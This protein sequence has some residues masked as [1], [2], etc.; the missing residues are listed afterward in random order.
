VAWPTMRVLKEL[1]SGWEDIRERS[2]IAG[3][4]WKSLPALTELSHPSRGTFTRPFCGR[5]IREPKKSI[6]TWNCERRGTGLNVRRWG[7]G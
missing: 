3:S 5:S 6:A 4:D 2:L 1:T 7:T